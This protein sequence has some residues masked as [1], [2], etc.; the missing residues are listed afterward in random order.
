MIVGGYTLDL[1]CDDERH[2]YK[3]GDPKVGETECD[4]FIASRAGLARRKARDAGWRLYMRDGLAVC[5]TCARRGKP[6]CMTPRNAKPM[7]CGPTTCKNG[8]AQTDANTWRH[9][10]GK[11]LCRECQR[12]HAIVGW[13]KRRLNERL[14][15]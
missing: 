10:S 5:P 12:Q 11:R 14:S 8:H 1:Y 6:K 3:Y 4:T 2:A 15:S 7:Q 13:E 9:W